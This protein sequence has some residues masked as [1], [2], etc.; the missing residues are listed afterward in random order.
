[1]PVAAVIQ[2]VLLQLIT[3]QRSDFALHPYLLGLVAVLVT[4]MTLVAYLQRRSFMVAMGERSLTAR[5]CL[6]SKEIFY[7][8]IRRVELNPIGQGGRRYMLQVIDDRDSRALKISGDK[9]EMQRV[10]GAL[11][12]RMQSLNKYQRNM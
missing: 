7:M 12:T 6:G 2:L 10:A 9:S 5:S 11:N 8:R 3:R 4:V 1:M